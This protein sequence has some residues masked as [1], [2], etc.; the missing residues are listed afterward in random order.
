MRWPRATASPRNAAQPSPAA[1]PFPD[2][3]PRPS[4]TPCILPKPCRSSWRTGR[5][6]RPVHPTPRLALVADD[7]VLRRHH[8]KS[9]RKSSREPFAQEIIFFHGANYTLFRAPGATP[10]QAQKHPLSGK[11]KMEQAKGCSGSHLNFQ[12][13]P[14]WFQQC[15]RQNIYAI[16][17][18]ICHARFPHHH[19]K[20]CRGIVL[21]KRGNLE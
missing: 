21:E 2:A 3:I 8:H 11:G 20:R 19:R 14:L 10:I 17:T 7:G 6:R 9:N 12:W 13:T 18:S 5:I 16:R 1:V 4:R 15:Q